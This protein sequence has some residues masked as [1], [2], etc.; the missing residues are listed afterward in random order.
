MDRTV[1]TEMNSGM[2]KEEWECPIGL[3]PE[4][5]IDIDDNSEEDGSNIHR[6]LINNGFCASTDDNGEEDRWVVQKLAGNANAIDKMNRRSRH[7]LNEC[8]HPSEEDTI[9]QVG[10]HLHDDL[11]EDFIEGDYETQGK[12]VQRNDF[13]DPNG[14]NSGNFTSFLGSGKMNM[15]DEKRK[16]INP[17]ASFSFKPSTGT[18]ISPTVSSKRK[19]NT[20]IESATPKSKSTTSIK[21][22]SQKID[23]TAICESNKDH[24]NQNPG[25]SYCFVPDRNSY[26][27]HKK[28]T[29]L[30]RKSKNIERSGDVPM[31]R[32]DKCIAKWHS[33]ADPMAPIEHQRFQVMV[34]ARLHARCHENSVKKAMAGLRSHFEMK[35]NSSSFGHPDSKSGLGSSKISSMQNR[36][37]SQISSSCTVS[38][39]MKQQ[40]YKGLT[41]QNLALSDPESEIAPILSSILFGNT[42]ARQIVQASQDL[43]NK[44][45]G[46]VPESIASLREITGI[47][48]KLAEILNVANR[49]KLYGV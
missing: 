7:F 22:S 34:A 11:P 30:V 46:E 15:D 19:P 36:I 43:L 33:F 20:K 27:E 35:D 2:I 24:H 37:H 6:S 4:H 14:N 42:K 44:F 38:K 40:H 39:N 28:S 16:H 47:G 10:G 26:K 18:V 17:F 31:G 48:P 1:E 8:D 3:T 5:A 25:I 9:N 29:S 13:L 45:Q 32:I 12:N 41:P 49:R 23:N 21:Q